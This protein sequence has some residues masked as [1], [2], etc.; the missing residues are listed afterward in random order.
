MY[1][2]ELIERIDET[3]E[4]GAWSHMASLLAAGCPPWRSTRSPSSVTAIELWKTRSADVQAVM[5]GC[6]QDMSSASDG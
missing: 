6:C 1:I 5:A 2:V 4:V 3:H